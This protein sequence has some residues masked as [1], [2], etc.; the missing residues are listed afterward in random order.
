VNDRGIAYC[1]ELATGQ[2]LHDVRLPVEDGGGVFVLE[3]TPKLPQLACNQFK[4]D[5][6]DFNAAP[7]VS[8]GQLFLRSNKFLY[9]VEKQ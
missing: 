8:N 3:A 2:K 7:A 1:A 5:D 4:S 9:C 6:S